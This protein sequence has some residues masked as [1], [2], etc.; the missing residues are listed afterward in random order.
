MEYGSERYGKE[1][2][3]EV[4]AMASDLWR[5]FNE[6]KQEEDLRAEMKEQVATSM[7]AYLSV[8]FILSVLVSRERSRAHWGFA[9]TACEVLSKF[10]YNVG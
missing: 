7:L 9:S 10:A 6:E 4:E 1:F 2:K 5:G 8:L 3:A